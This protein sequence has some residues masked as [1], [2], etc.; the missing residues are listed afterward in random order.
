MNC[1][2][3]KTKPKMQ[4]YMILQFILINLIDSN[5][6]LSNTFKKYDKMDVTANFKQYSLIRSLNVRS[7]F[8]C[9]TEC[10]NDCL[11]AVLS[12]DQQKL[13]CNLYNE[14]FYISSSY[15]VT[16]STSLFIRKGNLFYS[17]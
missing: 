16:E 3:F 14:S 17:K 9:L 10:K 8:S 5:S 4:R 13:K 6:D 12:E 1:K 7:K 2:N 11:T 15:G